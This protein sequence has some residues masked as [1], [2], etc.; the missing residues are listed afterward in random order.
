[1]PPKSRF[2]EGPRMMCIRLLLPFLFLAL[3][4]TAAAQDIVV[5]NDGGGPGFTTSGTWNAGSS[6]GWHSTTYVYASAP[7][8]LSTATWRTALPSTGNYEVLA[9]FLAS[10]NRTTRA[11]YTVTSAGGSSLVEISQTGVGVREVSLGV[12]PFI[13]GTSGSVTLSNTG[14]PGAHIA[15]A[16]IFRASATSIPV[17]GDA[18]QDPVY[19]Y[20]NST[21]TLRCRVTP[22][23]GSTVT[24]AAVVI[25]PRAS[26]TTLT[27]PLVDDGAHNDGA[28]ADG[29]YAAQVPPQASGSTVDFTFMAVDNNGHPARPVTG[30]YRVQGV[31][32]AEWRC[33]W[34]TSWGTG[35]LSAT[36]AQDLVNTCRAAN[37]NT[38]IVEVRKV[39]DACYNSS[40]E[41]R[42]TNISGGPNY[43]P[44]GTLL[45]LA[46]D[47]SGGKKRL[48]VHAWFVS[49]RISRG[50]ALA[51]NHIL[52]THPEYLMTDNNG[53]Y[54]T[55]DMFL[56]PG[57][58][59]V[60]DHNTS[61]ILDCLSKYDIDGINLDYIRYPGKTFGYNPVSVARFNTLYGR[62]GNPATTDTVWSDWRRECVTL[63]VKKGYI[64]AWK[65]KPHVVYTICGITGGTTDYR[66]SGTY[67]N[68]LQDWVGWL[69][70]G[71]IDYSNLMDYT[72]LDGAAEFRGWANLSFA[73]DDARG[74]IIGI[75]TYAHTNVAGSM[76]QLLWTRHNGG[77]LNIFDWMGEVSGN[78]EGATRADFYNTLRTQVYPEWVD[79]PKPAWKYSP[80]TGIIE[81]TVTNQGQPVDHA[82]VQVA[83]LTGSATVTDGS[84]WFGIL[85]V[86]PGNHIVQATR[87]GLNEQSTT[88]TIPAAGDVVTVDI[89]LSS[90]GVKSWSRY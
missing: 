15:D 75:S 26:G 3:G 30:S 9:A 10:A 6:P 48:Q 37:I 35:F 40:L 47:T 60:V 76:D 88:A 64:K 7:G 51:P 53:T 17:I 49:H 63:E 19:A 28:A 78:T 59:G 24:S 87:N 36:Q 73:N 20:E 89:D 8:D 12:F 43:D 65:M 74:S 14:D 50:E 46:H 44:L 2:W 82:T 13:A 56:D 57:H 45:T 34:V 31:P 16:M 23:I 54:Q 77:G 80:T 79:P 55:S 38:L 86:P 67:T 39:G 22:G 61:V 83:G 29:L 71:V 52:A 90:S 5:D 62:T 27:L 69:R 41:P 68:V 11:P 72:S 1:M 58:P 42:A 85:N 21:V 81:G 32:T 18:S 70:A 25:V 4:M 33:I 84:G 66:L